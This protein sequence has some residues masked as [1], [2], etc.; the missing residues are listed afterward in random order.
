MSYPVVVSRIQNRRGTQSQFL[1]LYPPGYL[2]VGGFGPGIVTT[3]TGASGNGS[4]V[5]LTFAA[6]SN[7][8][9]SNTIATFGTVTPGGSYLPNIY[10]NVPLTGGTG[11]GATATINVNGAGS[12]GSV[13]NDAAVTLTNGGTGY[14]AGD[15]L[16]AT[17]QTGVFSTTGLGSG[18]SVVVSTLQPN[19][20]FSSG[21]IAS[22]GA[23][24]SGLNYLPGSYTNVPLVGGHGTGAQATIVV[25]GATNVSS[26]VITNNGTGYAVGDELSAT[27]ASLG[28]PINNPGSGLQ[29]GGFT[30]LVA[31][32]TPV[33]PPGPPPGF[34]YPIGSTI[35]VEGITPLSYNGTYVV[36]ASTPTT[37]SFN[38]TATGSQI[39]A[40]TVSSPFNITN[41][42]SVLLPGEL[43]LCED[44]R[45]IYMGNLNGEYIQIAE[46]LVDGSNT[47]LAP[48]EITL[49]PAASFTIIPSLTYSAT[50]FN[51]MV[52]SIT[53]S[54]S[55]DW[56]TVGNTFSRN[57]SL[58]ITATA[59][60]APIPNPPFPDITPVTLTDNGT[61]IN[62]SI[63]DEI[64]FMAQYDV[65]FTNIEI[66][67]MHDF[68]TSLNFST[69]SIMWQPFA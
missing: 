30:V 51:T 32:I 56:N 59:N 40:G 4:V 46:L 57:G 42:P 52:Y 69:S 29:T 1:A 41:Y 63:P 35:V 66:L 38:S 37:V 64:T 33:L 44:S 67:Y 26:V 62:T 45:R 2:G 68:A 10:E 27:P 9:Y 21:P 23:I 54:S 15:I 19:G 6:A 18:F 50:P 39:I 22:T 28:V 48:L 25:N 3:T 36:T 34:T 16:S 31:T 53:D 55:L 65:T 20:V 47:F 24:Q 7:N 14:T 8:T 60:F 5:T 43:A 13:I 49:P 11:T 17:T 58:Q 12:V 61:E